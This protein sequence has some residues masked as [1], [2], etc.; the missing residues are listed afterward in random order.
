[1]TVEQLEDNEKERYAYDI[2]CTGPDYKLS[3]VATG[4]GQ[5]ARGRWDAYDTL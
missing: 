4:A 2:A 1:M 3:G 5:T